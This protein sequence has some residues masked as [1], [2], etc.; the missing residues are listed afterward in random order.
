MFWACHVSEIVLD[1]AQND[2]FLYQ[3]CGNLSNWRQVDIADINF[4]EF[5]L[6]AWI[7]KNDDKQYYMTTQNKFLQ[8][9]FRH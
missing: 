9:V 1:A 4:L 2:S 7:Y 6:C 5:V 8:A 3:E